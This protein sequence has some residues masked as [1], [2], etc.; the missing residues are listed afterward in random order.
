MGAADIKI[1]A[2][3]FVTAESSRF[4]GTLDLPELAVGP[5]TYRFEGPVDW[6]ADVTN[7]G[8]ALLVTG[9]A[10]GEAVVACS[11][12]LEDVPWSFQGDIEGYFLLDP[13]DAQDFEDDEDAPGEDEF[14]VLPADHVIDLEPLIR[15]A[16][17]VDAPQLPLC[18][19]DCKGLCP[20]CGANLNREAC[21]CGKGA[22]VEEFDRAAN[23][24]S[25]L[26]DLEFSDN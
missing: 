25:V 9:S 12:C 24:F 3:L 26:A 15:A 20:S 2:E 17:L 21:D 19:E 1:P 4:E 16:L 5:D 13:E 8:Q 22:D 14:D 10:Q 23:P 11:R 7:T 6:V 18:D